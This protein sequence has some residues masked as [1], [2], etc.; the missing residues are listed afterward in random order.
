VDARHPEIARS[1]DGNECRGVTVRMCR[2]AN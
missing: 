2:F 1:P